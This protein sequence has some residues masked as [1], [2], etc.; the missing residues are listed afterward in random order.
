MAAPMVIDTGVGSLAQSQHYPAA[1][2]S[3]CAPAPAPSGPSNAPPLLCPSGLATTLPMALD[4]GPGGLDQSIHHPLAG[5]SAGTPV[6]PALPLS[7]S[8]ADRQLSAPKALPAPTA[9]AAATA[10]ALASRAGRVTSQADCERLPEWQALASLIRKAGD[11]ALR[12]AWGF[13]RD[14]LSHTVCNHTRTGRPGDADALCGGYPGSCPWGAG[15]N[16]PGSG[17]STDMGCGGGR[18]PDPCPRLP[19]AECDH[20]GPGLPRGSRPASTADPPS[21]LVHSPWIR[22]PHPSGYH[23]GHQFVQRQP[24]LCQR[25]CVR[26]Q[27]AA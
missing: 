21:G 4:G 11:A 15:L 1:G 25:R 16:M 26:C 23:S 24:R 5:V 27:H 2:L 10:Q 9:R 19:Q 8:R 6:A 7:P 20:P 14:A 13:M 12:A 22:L 18:G 3:A 17:G